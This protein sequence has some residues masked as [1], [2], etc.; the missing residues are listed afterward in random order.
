VNKLWS[1]FTFLK[2]VNQNSFFHF[3]I[4]CHDESQS[5]IWTSRSRLTL[6]VPRYKCIFLDYMFILTICRGWIQFVLKIKSTNY[7]F[8]YVS[9]RFPCFSFSYFYVS[10]VAKRDDTDFTK[11]TTKIC[12]IHIK[13]FSCDIKIDLILDQSILDLEACWKYHK[14]SIQ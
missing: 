2:N 10:Y 4:S 7:T 3:H 6:C 12:K 8:S 1:F 11:S 5:D 13:E 14:I 9:A